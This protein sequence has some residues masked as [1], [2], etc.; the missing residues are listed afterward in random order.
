[1]HLEAKKMLTT[2]LT[3][4]HI[5]LTLSLIFLVLIQDSKGGGLGGLSGGNANTLLGATG[6]TSLAAKFT[7]YTAIGFA[8][9]CLGLAVLTSKSKK[10]VIDELPVQAK[11]ALAV[12]VG[13]S[14][15]P[16]PTGEPVSDATMATTEAKD[17]KT[18]ENK[19]SEQKPAA[20]KK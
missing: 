15:L 5:I 14:P 12:G 10:S 11:S 4:I 8:V 16:S 13:G 3:V 18:V 7:R 20:D 19:T 9:S 2:I 17:G 6:A 1:M